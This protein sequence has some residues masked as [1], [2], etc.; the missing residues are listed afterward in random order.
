[1]FDLAILLVIYL[2]LAVANLLLCPEN[3]AVRCGVSS[4]GAVKL[5]ADCSP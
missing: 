1:M 5:D 4:P 2:P 3:Y